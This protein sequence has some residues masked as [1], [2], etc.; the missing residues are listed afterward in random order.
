MLIGRHE[1]KRR[2][3]T[4]TAPAAA[5]Q[6]PD[7][8]PPLVSCCPTPR[9]ANPELAGLL[10]GHPQLLQLL[11]RFEGEDPRRGLLAAELLGAQDVQTVHRVGG[12]CWLLCS[13]PDWCGGGV[14]RSCERRSMLCLLL[15]PAQLQGMARG[16]AASSQ[17]SPVL[18]LSR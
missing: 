7:L 2:F 8:H 14:G 12:L 13:W 5:V 6:P 18:T 16:S 1:A 15:G 3:S 9:R 11:R 17:P 10:E 4:A